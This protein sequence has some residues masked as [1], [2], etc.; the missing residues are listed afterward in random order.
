[1]CQAPLPEF[2]GNLIS[3]VSGQCPRQICALCPAVLWLMWRKVSTGGS[4]PSW[5]F[6]LPILGT[7]PHFLSRQVA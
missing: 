5:R 1:M 4:D 3:E 7:L 6:D 2:P